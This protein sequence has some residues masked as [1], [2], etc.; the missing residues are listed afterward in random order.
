MYEVKLDAFNGPLDLL[1][2]LI[3]K[4]EI[5]IYDIPMKELTEQYMQYI[6]TMN[7]LEINI[8]SEYLVMAS[9]LLMIKSKMLLP[10]TS[11]AEDVDDDPRDELVGRLIEYQ[12]YKAYTEILNERRV[13][14]AFYFSK[15][16]TD[17]SHLESNETWNP[18]H[19][20]DLTEL[21][22]AYQK[23]KNRVEFQTPKTVDI[24]K[25]TF[26]IQQATSQV[27]EK[28]KQHESFNFFSLF[29]FTEPIEMVVTHFLAILEM[30]K[31]GIVNIEQP[32]SFDDI[33][34]L[35]GVNY[36]VAR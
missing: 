4:I 22:I 25:E 2:H 19:T 13:E 7:Q 16:P 35:R 21:M 36:G 31:S 27:S 30:S 1:L 26:T 9:E 32:K 17:L 33:N 12:N 6:H 5:D 3:Q 29:N 8:A 20:I 14:R 11:E 24:R 10:Q 23:V 15:H 34:I 28:L 18:D